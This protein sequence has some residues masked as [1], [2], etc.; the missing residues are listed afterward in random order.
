VAVDAPQQAELVH[1]RDGSP[2]TMDVFRKGFDAR[3]A[4]H[5][6]PEERVE[7]LTSSWRMASERF[8]LMCEVR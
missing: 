8:G 2:V 6:G 7:F 5:D 4:R 1:L 3:V